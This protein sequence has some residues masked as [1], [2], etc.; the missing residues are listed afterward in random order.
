MIS[1]DD[2]INKVREYDPD[3]NMKIIKDAYEFTSIAHAGTKRLSGEDYTQHSLA[4]AF[5]LTKLRL[6]VPIIAA[7]LLHDVPEDTSYTLEEIR[8]KFGK[9]I[10]KLVEGITKLGTLKY[11]GFERYAENLRKMFM[12]MAEDIRVILI[13]F[14]D[15]MHNLETLEYIRPD[16][17]RRIA[18]ETL[19]IYAP[20]ANR[21]GMGEI[22]GQLED[23]AF[24]YVYPKE[25][26]WI[27][28]IAEGKLK[29]E[30]KY[31]EKIKKTVEKMLIQEKIEYLSVHGRIKRLY[32]LYK[33]I[34]QRDRDIDKVYDFIALR[35]IVKNIADCY[36]VLGIIHKKWTP[37]KGRIK[38]YIAQ[39]KPNRYQSLHTTVFA[40]R[41][42]IVELQ[43]RDLQ[44]H[45][46]AEYG[47]ATH[48]RYKEADRKR[49][50]KERTVWIKNLLELQKK[51]QD[52]KKY[53]SEIKI[54][55]FQN[56]IFVFTPKGDVI[57]LPEHSTPIDF[58]YHIHTDI[59]NK[60]TGALINEE[61][62]P[63][64]AP[65]K[66]GDVVEILTSKNRQKP[67]VDW[68]NFIRTNV[69]REK[70]KNALKEPEDNKTPKS[71]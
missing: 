39:P 24:P 69:A 9:E 34:L 3:A 44:M 55:V 25:Y 22:K 35:I 68:L 21:L 57:D 50:T 18:L 51:V 38:D 59:G 15:R 26:T 61:I 48:W 31:I 37:L 66:S 10:T 40:E 27:K 19:E 6:D 2:I 23:L 7:G 16:K 62:A 41:G 13:K 60:C 71:T 45:Q 52:Y 46:L 32:S 63:L 58:A 42:K 4:T 11:R 47:I 20:I 70:I 53:L 65:L 54:D 56:R 64:D 14:A 5:N 12:A 28:K 49:M 30:K 36:R 43:I 1:I 67:N 17:R 33:K 29:I 8:K